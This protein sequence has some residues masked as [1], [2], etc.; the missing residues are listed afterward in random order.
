MCVCGALDESE[1]TVNCDQVCVGVLCVVCVCGGVSVT[2][3][4]ATSFIFALLQQ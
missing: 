4:P 2:T 3:F 1:L